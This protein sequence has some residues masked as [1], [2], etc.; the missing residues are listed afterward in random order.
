MIGVAISG[1]Q[2]RVPRY[3]HTQ[4]TQ[5]SGT[6]TKLQPGHQRIDRKHRISRPRSKAP[7]TLE[8]YT[9]E[10]REPIPHFRHT[11]GIDFGFA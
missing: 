9:R 11:L 3:L 7:C 6:T 8:S 2:A 10:W 5:L 1:S 4:T